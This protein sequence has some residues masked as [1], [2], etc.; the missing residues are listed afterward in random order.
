M[1]NRTAFF[2]IAFAFI[3]FVTAFAQTAIDPPTDWHL[4][5]P[6]TDHVQGLSVEKAYQ[7]LLKGR[8]ARSVIVAVVDTGVD[9]EHEDL[10]SVIWTNP[11]EIPGN[12]IDDDQNGYIDDI[13]GWNFIGGK[14]GNVNDDTYELTREYVRLKSKYGSLTEK[15]VPKKEKRDFEIY[16]DYKDKFEKRKAKESEQ[17]NLFKQQ[18]MLYSNME[19]NLVKSVDT[20][21][22]VL[23]KEKLT[24]EDVI[25]LQT[26]EPELLFSKGFIMRMIK[27]TGDSNLDTLIINWKESVAYYKEALDEYA[28]TVEYGYNEEFNPR[29]IVGDDYNNPLERNYGNNDVK[30]PDS[31]HGTHV[32]GTIAADRTN[33]IGIKGIADHVQIMSVRMLPNGDE[34]DKDVA[35]AIRYA[36]DNGAKILNMSF[37]K[38]FSPQKNVVDDAVRYAEQKGVILV[39][40]AG[41]DSEDIDGHMDF[42]SRY[43]LDGKEAKN[44][45]EV[46]AS[47]WNVDENLVA[48]FSNYG[49][50]SVDVFA[51]GEDIYATVPG[52]GYKSLSG[53]SMAAPTVAGV[54][55]LL[56][57]YFP[58]L[59]S[60]QVIDIIKKSSRKFDGLSVQKPGGGK[61]DFNALSNTGG[62]VNAYEAIKMAGSIKSSTAEH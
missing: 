8:P 62:L 5:D 33:E 23:H 46:G 27:N 61:T 22:V 1:I 17:Y 11:H 10:K 29:N 6:E 54:A 35:N 55:A 34:R 24:A 15:S 31:K 45:I 21:K 3:G 39:H 4:L 49:K 30:G 59:S 60:A 53:T 47:G 52:N 51:P 2:S 41:N 32:A 20:L 16:K 26:S 44:W 7:T 42:P 14:E 56:M 40:A 57:S 43:Y 18:Y 25:Q 36:V 37:G 38:G 58:D 13:H 9:T 50:K 48:N 19:K 12:G 28:S